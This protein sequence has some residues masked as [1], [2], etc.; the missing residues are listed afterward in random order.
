LSTQC[1]KSSSSA[2]V[3][4]QQTVNIRSLDVNPANLV[5]L[6]NSINGIFQAIP[7]SLESSLPMHGTNTVEETAYFL[8]LTIR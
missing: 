3:R 5:T 6:A 4:V 1:L 8:N 7:A 2:N